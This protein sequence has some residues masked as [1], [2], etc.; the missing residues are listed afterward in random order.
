[1]THR[2]LFSLSLAAAL[3]S[4]RGALYAQDMADEQAR[5]DWA[6]ARDALAVRVA[7][8]PED[9]DLWYRLAIAQALAGDAAASRYPRAG[10]VSCEQPLVAVS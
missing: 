5:V 9:V 2:I 4:P 7:G 10:A 8:A 3:L 1:M 6:E